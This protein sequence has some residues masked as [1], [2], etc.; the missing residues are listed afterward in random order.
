[1]PPVNSSTLAIESL[2]LSLL[3]DLSTWS[4]LVNVVN[5]AL[6]LAFFFG[7]HVYGDRFLPEHRP[8]S[9]LRTIR[10]MLHPNVWF[11]MRSEQPRRER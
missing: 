11:A 5:P 4:W 2:A 6:M 3:V 1:M 7:Q 8:A 10:A 9:P